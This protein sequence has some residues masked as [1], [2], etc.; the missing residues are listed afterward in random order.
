MLFLVLLQLS[1][2]S[3][4]VNCYN[5][6]EFVEG[7]SLDEWE[8][9]VVKTRNGRR[10]SHPRFQYDSGFGG[11]SGPFGGNGASGRCSTYFHAI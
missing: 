7:P 8:R 6:R 4:Y 10:I 1:C 9:G 11:E 3:L 5:D 2:V